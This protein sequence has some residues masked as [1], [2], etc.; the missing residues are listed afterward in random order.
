MIDWLIAWSFIYT[1]TLLWSNRE[2]DIVKL[3]NWLMKDVLISGR[4][5][6]IKGVTYSNNFFAYLFNLKMHTQFGRCRKTV[7]TTESAM[8]LIGI[9]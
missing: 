4:E 8:T 6:L 9:S 2:A 5:V 1:T 7:P 3:A